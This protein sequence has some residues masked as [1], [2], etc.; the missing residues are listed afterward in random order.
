MAAQSL[1]QLGTLALN[2]APD[3][4]M[5]YRQTPFG[6]QLFDIAERERVPQI[7][8]DCAENEFGRRLAPLEDRRSRYVLR[9]LFSLPA[10]ARQTCNTSLE[11]TLNAATRIELLQQIINQKAARVS[12]LNQVFDDSALVGIRFA[13][14]LLQ[15][16]LLEFLVLGQTPGRVRKHPAFVSLDDL[17]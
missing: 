11:D 14:D 3:C 12:Y 15:H 8:A 9:V 17:T 2:P 4:R 5:V 13:F 7:P 6:E 16:P 10:T 1:L